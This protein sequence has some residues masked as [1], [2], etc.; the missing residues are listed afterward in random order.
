MTLTEYDQR[1]EAL[2]SVWQALQRTIDTPESASAV[3]LLY[4]AVRVL[5][6]YAAISSGEAVKPAAHAEAKGFEVLE[7]LRQRGVVRDDELSA[8]REI[9][10]IRQQWN[11][12]AEYSEADDRARVDLVTRCLPALWRVV[13]VLQ[14]DLRG[15]RPAK[16]YARRAVRWVGMAVGGT[17]LYALGYSLFLYVNTLNPAGWRVTYYARPD[18]TQPRAVRHERSLALD[19]GTARPAMFVPADGWSAKWEGRL[20]VPRD[21]I[22]TFNAQADDGYR[23][24]IDGVCVLDSWD[25]GGWR[26]GRKDVQLELTKGEHPIR[27][28]HVDRSGP[29]EIRV[30]WVGGSISVSTPIGIPN[31]LK[32]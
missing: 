9:A 24:Y 23:L 16:F 25:A 20:V 1:W 30:R 26:A 6:Q 13:N 7:S 15:Q 32:P 19:Y 17:V 31:I 12:L 14:D 5:G 3:R 18:L 22:Y 27:V 4:N 8:L 11:A 2:T 29:A 10:V 28:E 21:G